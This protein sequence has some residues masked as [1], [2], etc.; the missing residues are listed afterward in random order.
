MSRDHHQSATYLAETYAFEGT[1]A[2]IP[3][4]LERLTAA[5]NQ[6]C[7]GDWW[8]AGAAHPN[9]TLGLA[10]SDS[11]KSSTRARRGS[12]DATLR[13]ADHM[14]TMATLVHELAHAWCGTH[15]NHDDQFRGTNIA[16]TA[17]ALGDDY[18]NQ[19]I[20]GYARCGLSWA[21][22]D[23]G[24]QARGVLLRHLDT[25]APQRRLRA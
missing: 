20:E 21:P 19:L 14:T 9:V 13:I 10:R 5:A 11:W 18:A 15:V 2:E 24:S 4:G 6:L 12:R 8:Q 1:L 22:T 23:V 7:A 16:L 25:A 3:I 17:V